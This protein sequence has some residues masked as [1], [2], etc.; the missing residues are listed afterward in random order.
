MPRMIDDTMIRTRA[1]NRLCS[2]SGMIVAGQPGPDA[3]QRHDADD[4]AHARGRRDQ[5]DDVASTR[6]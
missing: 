3:G 1:R 4:D 2:A 6:R 5:R